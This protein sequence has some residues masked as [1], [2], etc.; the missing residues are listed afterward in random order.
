MS[1]WMLVLYIVWVT[2][3]HF[4]N[5]PALHFDEWPW[6]GWCFSRLG[7]AQLSFHSPP[8]FPIPPYI[9][10]HSSL[11]MSGCQ[12]MNLGWQ[13]ASHDS[14]LLKCRNTQYSACTQLTWEVT[15]T[16]L[17]LLHIKIL[18]FYL[19]HFKHSLVHLLLFISYRKP[20]CFIW[21]LCTIGSSRFMAVIKPGIKL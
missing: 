11:V 3:L 10:I 7:Q 14:E 5:F 4:L 20:L 6:P 9:P 16:H 13:N 15:S 17:F 12:F 1:S 18:V 8:P 2:D 19:C 21:L